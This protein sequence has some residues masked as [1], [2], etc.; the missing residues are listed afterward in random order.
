MTES[1]LLHFESSFKVS[2]PALQLHRSHAAGAGLCTLH[3]AASEKADGGRCQA[4]FPSLLASSLWVVGPWG[5][6]GLG[7]ECSWLE[8]KL[9]QGLA[10]CSCLKLI[11]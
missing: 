7:S 9:C 5:Q 10:L 4:A 6:P 3:P 1:S 8:V 2:L 11:N